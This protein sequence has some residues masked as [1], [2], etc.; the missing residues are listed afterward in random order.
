[1]IGGTD[2]GLR[3]FAGI[4]L[5]RPEDHVGQAG[6][7]GRRRPPGH[8]RTL[9]RPHPR[10]TLLARHW[11]AQ[12]LAPD[13]LAGL[14]RSIEEGNPVIISARVTACRELSDPASRIELEAEDRAPRRTTQGHVLTRPAMPPAPGP[15]PATATEA[16]AMARSAL[17]WLAGADAAALTTSEQAECLRV[18]EQAE[19]AHTAARASVSWPR[20]ARPMAAATTAT[21]QPRPGCGGRPRSPT[22]PRPA[23]SGRCGA[24]PP[25]PSS[26]APWPTGRS[27]RRGRA[28]SARGPT[29]SPPRCATTRTRSCC[30]PPAA[31]RNWR[32]SAAWPKRSSGRPPGRTPTAP[33]TGSMTGR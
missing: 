32:I 6:G 28:R 13:P 21:A 17:A 31:A 10:L 22:A 5:G 18:L 20:S 19:S 30:T 12:R 24:W 7:D 8:P 11:G 29:R 2:C 9:A 33:T 23:R 15:A 25:I 14:W 27:P 3:T 1:M 26:A 4:E 16:A